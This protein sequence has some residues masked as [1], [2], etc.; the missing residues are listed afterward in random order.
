MI[1]LSTS[2]NESKK[3]KIEAIWNIPVIVKNLASGHLP[4]LY[5]L[6]LKKSYPEKDNTW[7]PASEGQH[8]RKLIGLFK[9]DYSNK[10]TTMSEAIDTISLMTRST[11]KQTAK[12]ITKQIK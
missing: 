10:P 5:Y 9:K 1:E 8:L 6:F 4:R 2:N 11:I 7:E 3:Y 12:T